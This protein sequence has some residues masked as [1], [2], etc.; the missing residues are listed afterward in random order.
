MERRSSIGFALLCALAYAGGVVAYLPLLT[1]LLPMQV[2]VIAGDQRFG[3][4]ALVSIAGAATAGGANV[5]FGW[6]SD[7]SRERGGGRRPWIGAGLAATLASYAAIAAARSPL[8]IGAAIVLFQVALNAMLAPTMALVAEEVPERQTSL[9]TGMFAAGPPLA[10]LL[11]VG[12]A[13][14]I[15][16]SEAG[17]LA[18]VGLA[19]TLCLAPLLV[20]PARAATQPS[21]AGQPA[22][23]PRDLAIAWTARLL[24]QIAGAVLF[25]DLLYLL[26]ESGGGDG[27]ATLARMGTLTM[28][29][30]LAPLPVAVAFGR[31]SDRRARRKPVLV[32]TAL[33]AAL[34]LAVMAFASERAGRAGGFLLFSVGWGSFLPLQVGQIMRLLPDPARRGRDLGIFNLANTAPVLVG[35]GLAWGMATPRHTGPLLLTLAGLSLAGGLMTLAV[36]PSR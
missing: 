19:A 21:R 2:A 35:Q 29:A 6:L 34:G 31:W 10:S 25:A 24:V 12:L 9:T 11:S 27:S 28:V 3:V 8:A 15:F 5:L 22:R 23:S 4:L 30:N 36:R 33:L 13:A 14:P 1:V 17:R 20:T 7:R 18:A 32:L 16:S 26:E